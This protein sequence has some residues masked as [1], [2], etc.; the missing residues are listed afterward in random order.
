MSTEHAWAAGFFDGE[1][2]IYL[3]QKDSG[4][5][6]IVV[7]VDQ[8]VLPPLTRLKGIFG[9]QIT[10]TKLTSTGNKVWRWSLCNKKIVPFLEAIFPYATVK[11]S[12]IDIALGWAHKSRGT[13]LTA[14]ESALR[15]HI[16]LVLRDMKR[17][18][19]PWYGLGREYVC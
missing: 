15:A 6:S 9:G 7:S 10:Q 12:Q 3:S 8:T 5:S 11:K 2:C 4:R 19:G 18:R 1:G 17:G 14:E 13:S 16:G